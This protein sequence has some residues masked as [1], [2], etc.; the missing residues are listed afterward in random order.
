MSRLIL[1]LTASAEM[2]YKHYFD[3]GS[4][5]YISGVFQPI[6]YPRYYSNDN[7]YSIEEPICD[8]R[9]SNDFVAD[10]GHHHTISLKNSPVSGIKSKTK[11]H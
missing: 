3:S 2:C 7:P 11:K 4:I 10:Q 1:A 5:S 6:T 8:C 9:D